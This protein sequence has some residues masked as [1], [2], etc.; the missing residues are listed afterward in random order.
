MRPASRKT[1]MSPL[2]ERI[3]IDPNVCFG[4]PCIRGTRIWASLILDLLASGMSEDEIRSDY[5]SLSHDDILAAIA[6]DAEPT[7]RVGFLASWKAT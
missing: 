7:A 5:T 4:N 3:T 2:L 6:Y 1:A